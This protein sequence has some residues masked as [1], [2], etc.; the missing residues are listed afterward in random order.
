MPISLVKKLRHPKVDDLAV[1][2]DSWVILGDLVEDAI[3]ESIGELLNVVFSSRNS[4]SAG[5]TCGHARKAFRT[6]RSGPFH[7]ISL[8]HCVTFWV[9]RCSM[10]AYK[11]SS[12][13]RT[14]TTSI[15]KCRKRC[16]VA[17]TGG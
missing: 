3:E 16:R 17:T 11:S 2:F 15:R 1:C 4:L 6:M 9:G 7:V 12:F 5:C 10:P 8:R 14:P 13:S